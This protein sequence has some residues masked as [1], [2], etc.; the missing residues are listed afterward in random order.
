M[1]TSARNTPAPA[2]VPGAIPAAERAAH[3]D[4]VARLFGGDAREKRA[5]ENGYEFRFDAAA[6]EDV[7]R[8]VA[9][10]RE[11]CPFLDFEI[12]VG[13]EDGA[14]RLRLTGPEGTREFLEAELPG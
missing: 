3:F 4:L 11:C 12:D 10:E 1:E 5:L 14:V 2:C 8:F 9:N 13:A 7:A 6:F